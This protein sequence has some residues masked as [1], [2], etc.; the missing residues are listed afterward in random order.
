MKPRCRYC[1]NNAT[2]AC[3]VALA[4]TGVVEAMIADPHLAAGLNVHQGH[5]TH[6]AVAQG[7]G[8]DS[9]PVLEALTR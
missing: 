1:V 8:W 9:V 2:L 6:P 7:L 5:L 3:V 4:D